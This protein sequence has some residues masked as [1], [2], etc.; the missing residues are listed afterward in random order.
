MNSPKDNLKFKYIYHSCFLLELEKYT[1]VFD[2]YK[3]PKDKE[4]YLNEVFLSAKSSN[5]KILIFSS[6]GHYDHFNLE[7]LKWDRKYPNVSYILSDDI[8]ESNSLIKKNNYFIAKEN[9]KI[10]FDSNVEIY[11][12][13][14][15]DLGVSFLVKINDTLI[16]HAGDLNWWNWGEEDTEEEALEMETNFKSIVS[17]IENISKKLGNIEIAFF[18]VDP[19]LGIHFEDGSK[20][21]KEILNPKILVPMHFEHE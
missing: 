20:Y 4:D 11:S 7:I 1:L 14:S 2:Y 10:S 15:T 16:F 6:H 21:F 9:E 13:G 18:P 17:K 12:F 5:K 8:Y 3:A 19:R